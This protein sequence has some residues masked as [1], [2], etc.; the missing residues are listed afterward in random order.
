[1]RILELHMKHFGKFEDERMY[2][3]PG[4]NIIYGGNE[5]GKSTMHAFIR[6]M[7]FGIGNSRGKS[8][9]PD[10]YQLRQPWEN[11]TYFAGSMRIE[12]H[13]KIYRIERNFYR[14]D[15][16]V[17]LIC[18]TDGQEL[19][20]D[21]RQLQQL[22]DGMNEAVFVNTIFVSQAGAATD[23]ALAVRLREYMLNMQENADASV[24]VPQ[25][26]ADLRKQRRDLE[27]KR[28]KERE[29]TEEKIARKQLEQEY[30]LSLLE[31]RPEE[32]GIR[33]GDADGEE[34]GTGTPASYA[35]QIGP[36]GSDGPDGRDGRDGRS[37]LE[38]EIGGGGRQK[39]K[40]LSP[41]EMQQEI[42]RLLRYLNT[43]C[44]ILTLLGFL[45]ALVT[46]DPLV[47]IMMICTGLLF[48]I[49]RLLLQYFEK[50]HPQM[51][52]QAQQNGPAAEE[53]SLQISGQDTEDQE[54]D[55]TGEEAAAR[56]EEKDR[57]EAVQQEKEER[58]RE[59]L[60][61]RKE[62]EKAVRKE[63][64][65]RIYHERQVMLANV[66]EELTALYRE[67][68]RTGELDLEC[69]AIDLAISRI[70]ELSAQVYK[71]GGT[72]FARKSSQ[73]LSELTEGRYTAISLDEK[74]QVRINTP[75]KLLHLSQVSYGT[76]EQIYFA[77]RM[78]AG[79]MLGGES[80]PLILDEP[81]AMY[82]DERM[83]SALRWMRASGRQVLLFT[84]QT[85]EH[86]TVR[87]LKA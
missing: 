50:E 44:V 53:Q 39:K 72:D 86:E 33:S 87:R 23:E 40:E 78:A 65:D 36:D 16:D 81:F 26:L 75:D 28:R 14:N 25:A 57:E 82:D 19:P 2:F 62:G 20:A 80:L 10:E 69:E 1:M 56:S 18:E 9:R 51:M 55:K 11:G 74:M 54:T 22:L 60:R 68:D 45:C 30:L 41:Q 52:E 63:E 71:T 34:P 73:I 29:L 6:A 13:D 3:E 7:L 24:N 83:E 27:Q 32:K 49:I 17:R 58:E 70:T 66:K 76:M 38:K 37:G 79:Q 61:A 42:G 64:R 8:G 5:T 48:L 77:L 67:L 84:C 43:A 85:R 12:Y 21:A 35:E 59:I 47:R 4:I 31:E 46:Q 15:R